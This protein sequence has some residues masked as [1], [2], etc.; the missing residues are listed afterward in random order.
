MNG[1]I[2]FSHFSFSPLQKKL[3]VIV[4]DVLKTELPF[5]DVC[6]ANLPY[7]VTSQMYRNLLNRTVLNGILLEY[8]ELVKTSLYVKDCMVLIRK[9]VVIKH[10]PEY[11]P[12]VW[13]ILLDF[14]ADSFQTVITPAIFQVIKSYF[15]CFYFYSFA[16][17]SLKIYCNDLLY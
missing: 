11:V 6:V 10:Q 7:Q 8:S 13:F 4:G 5:F 15:C 16:K 2:D 14:I 12:H 17:F 3:Q 1:S 9:Y